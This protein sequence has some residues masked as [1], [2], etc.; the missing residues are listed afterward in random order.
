MFCLTFSDKPKVFINQEL[1]TLDIEG[2][3]KKLCCE[4]ETHPNISFI[5]WF[6]NYNSHI[7]KTNSLCLL[8][9]QLTRQDSNNYTCVAGNEIG[10]GSFTTSFVVFCKFISILFPS[11]VCF[12]VFTITNYSTKILLLKDKFTKTEPLKKILSIL[13]HQ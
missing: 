9:E 13:I 3:K 10:N 4:V 2:S 8:F 1:T 7:S 6:K 12:L 5:L 11:L